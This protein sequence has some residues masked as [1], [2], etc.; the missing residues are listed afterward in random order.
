[1]TDRAVS[2][3][4]RLVGSAALEPAKTGRGGLGG[5]LVDLLQ[6]SVKVRRSRL[7]DARRAM[8]R[9]AVR[10]GGTGPVD[11]VGH[12]VDGARFERRTCVIDGR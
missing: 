6:Q 12:A 4:D 5:E 3:A 10:C 11:R 7:A 2:A 8:R 1:M 9:H